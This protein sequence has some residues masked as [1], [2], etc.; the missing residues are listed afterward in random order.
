MQMKGLYKFLNKGNE[1]ADFPR[2]SLPFILEFVKPVMWPR[3]YINL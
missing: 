2:G 1:V 3:N